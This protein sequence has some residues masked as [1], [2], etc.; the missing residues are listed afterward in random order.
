MIPVVSV[1]G[2][3]G[4]G[5]TT[6]LESVVRVLKARRYRVAVIKHDVHDFDMD[7]PGK[8]TWRLR[9]AGSDIVVI[10]ARHKLAMLENVT[11]ERTLNDLIAM[12]ADRVDIVL[13]EGYRSADKRKIEVLRKAK[14][15]RLISPPEDLL[16]I[17]TDQL[18]DATTPR[19]GFDDVEAVTDL[20]EAEL[21]LQRSTRRPA[22]TDGRPESRAAPVISI[23]GSSGAG[24]T[25]FLEKLIPELKR[26]GCRV[27]AVKHDAGNFEIDRRGKDTYRLKE[28]GSDLV[29]ISARERMALQERLDEE[30]SVMELAAGVSNRVDVV[31]TEGR[32][33]A[34]EAKIEVCRR[35]AG[36][37]LLAID[38]KRLAFVTD[39]RLEVDAPQF[40][41]DDT[42]GVSDLLER[43]FNLA[44]ARPDMI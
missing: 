2:N 38:G 15:S 20:L 11:P 25:T 13:T 41:L 12:V 7:Q 29:I 31:L 27:A 43:R 18:F 10:A 34:A 39:Q 3:S 6:L 14:A 32:K 36:Q 16:A 9:E 37:P 17:V 19:F 44:V 42:S 21:G 35:D 33:R 24:K 4:A 8:D 30:R 23:I 28:A 1:V 5:K 22:I 26:R 40:G